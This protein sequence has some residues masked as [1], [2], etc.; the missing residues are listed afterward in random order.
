MGS[1]V[2]PGKFFGASR[3]QPLNELRSRLAVDPKMTSEITVK[4]SDMPLEV[5]RLNTPLTTLPAHFKSATTISTSYPHPNPS[6]TP[7]T[8]LYPA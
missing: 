8:P 5:G 6:F 1:L 3:S 7:L 4:Q 2:S